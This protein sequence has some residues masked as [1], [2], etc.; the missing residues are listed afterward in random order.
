MSLKRTLG[1]RDVVLFNL[2]AIL[3]LR[4]IATAAKAGPSAIILWIVAAL[5]FFIPQ[6]LAVA[7]LSSRYPAEGGIYAWTKQRFGDRHAYLCGWCYWV[8]NV[9]YYPQLLLST[10]I[11]ALYVVGKGDSGLGDQ[12]LYVLP[13]DALRPV[14][15]GRLQHR[16]AQ[17]RESG[18][19]MPAD[20]AAT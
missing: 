11:V 5:M 1:I 20:S 15:R 4:W 6:G 2:V 18:C 14:D 7:E 9:L 10:A 16:W 12:W 13:D 8:V 3:G 19:R 17:H